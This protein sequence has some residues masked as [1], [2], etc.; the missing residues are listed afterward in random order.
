ML[1]ETELEYLAWLYEIGTILGIILFVYCFYLIT[2]IKQ[3][4]PGGNIVKKWRIIQI[5]IIIVSIIY[6][7]DWIV[8]IYD[9][10]NVLFILGGIVR[11]STSLFITI[12]IVL[13]YK[14]YRLVLHKDKSN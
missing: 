6:I 14:T 9:L 11:L 12:L 7:I 3:L 4:F 2:K 13:F 10:H 1:Q 8:W 5:L